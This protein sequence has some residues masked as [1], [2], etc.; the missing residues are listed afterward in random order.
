LNPY[1]ATAK[2]KTAIDSKPT[3]YICHKF[4]CSQPVTDWV[5]LQKLL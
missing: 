2:G 1:A 3:A 5:A 4:T